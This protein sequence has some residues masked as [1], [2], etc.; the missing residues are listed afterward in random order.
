MRG[1]GVAVSVITS[2]SALSC[3]KRSLS[4]TPKRCSSSTTM[5]PRSRNSTSF[6][7][8]TMGADHDVDL[9]PLQT[10]HHV[11]L[12]PG[13]PEAGEDLHP[14]RKVGQPLAEG[15]VVLL[16]ENRRRHENG[17]LLPILHRLEGG[18]HRH[19]GLS[20]ADV[21]ADQAV[22]R[23]RGLHVLLD[24][25]DR[26]LLVRRL[27]VDERR[28]HVALPR[29]VGG[30]GE[31]LARAAHGAHAQELL[32]HLLDRLLRLLLGARPRSAAEARHGGRSLPLLERVLGHQIELI[33]RDEELVSALVVR[34][35]GN[36]SRARPP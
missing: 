22:H 20:V 2:A 7:R 34:S 32:G 31:S 10:G 35:R 29:G 12:F 21:A 15:G 36:R 1:I 23:L 5:S 9:S 33:G 6:W 17:D 8:Q 24:V 4:L 30:E 16:G 28:L 26:P 14:H 27:V 11:G 25:G 18:A 13:G 19:L 3:F